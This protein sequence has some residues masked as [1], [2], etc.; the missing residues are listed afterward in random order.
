MPQKKRRYSGE[1]VE[2]MQFCM[3]NKTGEHR[4]V[5]QKGG[6]GRAENLFHGQDTDLFDFY[7]GDRDHTVDQNRMWQLF[8]RQH[9]KA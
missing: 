8:V 4:P 1:D 7:P 9:K 3:K 6:R 2:K 5:Q